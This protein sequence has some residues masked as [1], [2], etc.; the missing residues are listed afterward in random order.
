MRRYFVL[1]LAAV[2]AG[3]S[4]EPAL[5]GNSIEPALSHVA[6]MVDIEQYRK[7]LVL[8]SA[9]HRRKKKPKPHRT[10]WVT[11]VSKSQL[12]LLNN[13]L[14]WIAFRMV[15]KRDEGPLHYFV[16]SLD[17]I[18]YNHC[19][20]IK[21]AAEPHNDALF[22]GSTKERFQSLLLLHCIGPANP[23]KEAERVWL[24]SPLFMQLNWLKQ[25]Q[26]VLAHTFSLHVIAS[27][28]DI[29]HF[30]HPLLE[31]T[32][33]MPIP[34]AAS[35]ESFEAALTVSNKTLEDDL[36]ETYPIY[37]NVVERVP[38]LAFSRYKAKFLHSMGNFNHFVA[39]WY[40]NGGLF[41]ASVESAELM[42]V[43]YGMINLEAGQYEQAAMNALLHMLPLSEENSTKTDQFS[44]TEVSTFY[45]HPMRRRVSFWDADRV[46]ACS[47]ACRIRNETTDSKEVFES[48]VREYSKKTFGSVHYSCDFREN[49]KVLDMK[50][51]DTWKPSFAVEEKS[52][53][54]FAK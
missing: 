26:I 8:V 6:R 7:E 52:C 15:P 27:D 22:D 54:Y 48:V 32:R 40:I 21:D 3:N 14:S 12:C 11:T 19:L 42:K 36:R 49:W 45:A 43:W 29:L 24:G 9:L 2:R 33:S 30:H 17:L 16:F 37:N 23:E 20:A 5:A 44:K 13:Y 31:T 38:F 25:A 4:I 1:S 41:F 34:I 18:S 47:E 39:E 46:C 10:I 35:L 50:R 53:D 51:D 28:L